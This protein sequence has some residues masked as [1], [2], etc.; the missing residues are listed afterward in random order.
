MIDKNTQGNQEKAAVGKRT[1]GARLQRL[2]YLAK[3]FDLRDQY[4]RFLDAWEE[5]RYFRWTLYSI[6][7]GGAVL[8]ASWIW[9]HPWW[10]ERASV[11]MAR[12]WMAAGRYD[13]ATVSI[14]KA[15]SIAPENPR[16]WLMASDIARLSGNKA[17]SLSYAHYAAEVSKWD[18]RYVTSWIS[19]ALQTEKLEEAEKAAGHLS[20]SFLPTSSLAQRLVGE[21]AR[22]RNRFSLAQEH[23]E[24]AVKLDGPIAIDEVPLGLVLLNSARPELRQRGYGLLEKW[25]DQSELGA[26]AA[27]ALLGY[28]TLQNDTQGML[29]WGLALKRHPFCTV[30]DIP[31]CLLALVKSDET[32]FRQVLTEMEKAHSAIP[33]QAAMLI[34]WLNQIGQASEA[35]RWSQTLSAPVR[36]QSG[37]VFSTAESLRQTKNWSELLELMQRARFGSDLQFM[38]WSY[39][40]LAARE[41]GQ[42]D[43]ENELWQTLRAHAETDGAHAFFAGSMIYTW[44]WTKEGVELFKIASEAHGLEIQALG[45]LLRHY[46]VHRDAVGQYEAYRRLYGLRPDDAA[47]GNNY[48]FFAALTRKDYPSA[49]RISSQN[50]ERNPENIVYRST[51]AFVLATRGA[52]SEASQ[53]LGPFSKEWKKSSALAFTYGYLL[54]KT[55]DKAQARSIISTLNLELGSIQEAELLEEALK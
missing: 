27:R 48:A 6:F 15:L 28:A 52:Y 51:Y 22:R 13:R 17:M 50:F 25:A 39:S 47:L 18:S 11:A 53:V 1:F 31:T 10:S 37:V 54:A 26:S 55:G 34:G 19:V 38:C 43:K 46:Q 21:I 36:N 44:G 35:F 16:V 30:G 29:K 9:I 3:D 4:W 7:V 40:M 32:A 42:T 5:R 41:L 23:F 2:L 24:T 20:E 12:Q 14:Q 33:G 8:A 49:E 45:A